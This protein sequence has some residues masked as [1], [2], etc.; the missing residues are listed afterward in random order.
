MYNTIDEF[1]ADCTQEGQSTQK[2]LDVLTDASLKQS[3]SSDDRTL[4]RIAW[5][6][7]TSTPHMLSAFGLNADTSF[8]TTAVP[9]SAKDIAEGFRKASANAINI[10]RQQWSDVSLTEVHNV[11]GIDMPKAVSLSLLV[12]HIIHHRGQ[13]TV[14][15]R[16]A[17]LHVPG[18]YGPAREEW[19]GI[20]MEAPLV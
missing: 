8:D 3:V 10:V 15:M 17:G 16:Q 12:R 20:G 7:V 11:F 18:I 1:V 13:M 6:I 9:S 2:V 5:H 19:A 4:G 14:L